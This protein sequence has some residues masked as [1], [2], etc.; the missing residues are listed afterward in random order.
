MQVLEKVAKALSR[1][2]GIKIKFQGNQ[3]YTDYKTITL[4]MLPLDLN[5]NDIVKVRGYCDH[6]ISHLLN[7]DPEVTKLACGA[8][9]EVKR[10]RGLLEDFRCERDIAN[11]YIGTKINMERTARVLDKEGRKTLNGSDPHIMT[12]LWIEGRRRVCGYKLDGPSYENDIKAAFGKDIF[13]RMKAMGSGKENCMDAL[14]LAKQMVETFKQKQEQEQQKQEREQQ[15]QGDNDNKEHGHSNDGQENEE[16]MEQDSAADPANSDSDGDMDSGD[17]GGGDD[18]GENDTNADLDGDDKNDDESDSGKAD[19]HESDETDSS[20]ESQS[21]QSGLDENA[22]GGDDNNDQESDQ[23]W[24]MTHEDLE[25]NLGDWD[26]SMNELQAEIERIAEESL[27]NETPT[28]YTTEYDKIKIL[29]GAYNANEYHQHKKRLGSLNMLKAKLVK[30]FLTS[31]KSRWVFDKEE[32]KINTRRL[33]GVKAGNRNIFKE[34]HVR[35]AQD[36]AITLLCDFSG[37]M[38][39]NGVYDVMTATVLFLETLKTAKIQTEVLGFTTGGKIPGM[40]FNPYS[41]EAMKWTR[42]ESIVTYVVKEFSEPLNIK[43]KQRISG[44]HD[45]DKARRKNNCDADSLLVAAERLRKQ[46]Q[47]RKIMF[48]LSDGNPAGSGNNVLKEMQLKQVVKDLEKSGI[49]VIGIGMGT[50]TSE[51]Y[52]KHILIESTS[53]IA[54]TIYGEL[55]KLLTG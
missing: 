55:K 36:T 42:C 22:L 33:V 54:S 24:K 30:L 51:F 5:E 12:K 31:Q 15:E 21:G 35:Q 10:V 6:E 9:E 17:D 32:G 53:G 27:S 41:A 19:E 11:I 47:R 28:P 49:E 39:S 13:D 7:T 4:P 3:A 50:D 48:V 25:S 20:D 14:E 46:P 2:Y 23:P 18:S 8:G 26:D 45:R 44:A 16:N 40:P 52:P 43:V 34:K 38:G 37:S 29:K 1:N